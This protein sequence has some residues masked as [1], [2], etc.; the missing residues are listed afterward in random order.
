M[1]DGCE[2]MG[3]GKRV[4]LALHLSLNLPLLRLAYRPSPLTHHLKKSTVTT[5]NTGINTATL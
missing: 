5:T 3:D 4:L 2:A 1:G